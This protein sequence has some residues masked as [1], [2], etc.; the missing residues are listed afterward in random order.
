MFARR[1]QSTS[2]CELGLQEHNIT[3]ETRK[4]RNHAALFRKIKLQC[5]IEIKLGP[6]ENQAA[7]SFRKSYTGASSPVHH[8]DPGQKNTQ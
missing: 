3:R 8:V 5:L 6:N 1:V 2:F 4:K 7:T